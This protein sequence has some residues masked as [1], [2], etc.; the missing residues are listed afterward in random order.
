MLAIAERYHFHLLRL[1]CAKYLG[2]IKCDL[3]TPQCDWCAHH[4]ATC[5][6]E[7]PVRWTWKS[8]RP[9]ELRDIGSQNNERVPVKDTRENPE[10]PDYHRLL[11]CVDQYETSRLMQ[12]TPV[13]DPDSFRQIMEHSYNLYPPHRVSNSVKACLVC[14]FHYFHALRYG[15]TRI[16]EYKS[17]YEKHSKAIRSFY[18]HILG[19]PTSKEG[20]Q[21]LIMMAL[22]APLSGDGQYAVSYFS[23]AIQM[24][25]ELG[26]HI[27]IEHRHLRNL[28]WLCYTLDKGPFIY[29][30]DPPSLIDDALCDLSL[31]PG[32]ETRFC[33]N[34][35]LIGPHAPSDGALF[36][37]D[38]RL[39]ILRSSI[40]NRLLVARNR[41]KPI[42]D[43]MRDIRELDSELEEWRNCLPPSWKLI[44][45]SQ[46]P[47]LSSIEGVSFDLFLVQLGYYWC[48]RTIHR[49]N[50]SLMALSTTHHEL[51]GCVLSSSALCLA[52][53]RS[54]LIRLY[55]SGRA[56]P[57]DTYAYVCP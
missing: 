41:N 3:V 14:F 11:Q 38:L 8:K 22:L 30:N 46:N 51:Q 25:F 39:S 49:A 12:M 40:R 44:T 37:V 36:P 16:T 43:T 23:A 2:Q 19:E 18:L 27:M 13:I 17:Q 6:F 26:G 21:A 4:D 52:A 20:L 9:S 35:V 29:P 33:Q 15:P 50:E 31:P 45:L 56:F 48:M 1:T 32:Y 34:F 5:T 42:S 53:S 7:R 54:A 55:T 47:L 10:L 28:F 57:I 24:V